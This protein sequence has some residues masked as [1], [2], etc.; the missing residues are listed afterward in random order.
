MQFLNDERESIKINLIGVFASCSSSK[1][2]ADTTKPVK[3]KIQHRQP[4]T[5][6][7]PLKHKNT[8][9]KSL[10]Q[11]SGNQKRIQG[12]WIA[13]VANINWPSRTI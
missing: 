8:G 1:T 6:P 5:L 12:A 10:N 4:K 7:L 11:S 3:I 13:S 2:L 9:K